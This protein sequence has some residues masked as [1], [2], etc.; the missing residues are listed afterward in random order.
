LLF[1][2]HF[3][4]YQHGSRIVTINSIG[5]PRGSQPL[6]SATERLHDQP[7]TRTQRIGLD[8]SGSVLAPFSLGCPGTQNHVDL[9]SGPAWV[10]VVVGNQD[11]ADLQS[12]IQ[13]GLRCGDLQVTGHQKVDGSVSPP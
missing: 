3:M 7:L 13:S 9:C 1:Q 2:A 8:L 10:G 5:L 6:S 12:M 4:H 11:A